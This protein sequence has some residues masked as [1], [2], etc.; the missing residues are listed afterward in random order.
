MNLA[1]LYNKFAHHI[2]SEIEYSTTRSQLQIA[3]TNEPIEYYQAISEENRIAL[4]HREVGNALGVLDAGLISPQD[5]KDGLLRRAC[6]LYEDMLWKRSAEVNLLLGD[7]YY[8]GSGGYEN[9][10]KAYE[11]YLQAAELGCA[12]AIWNVGFMNENGQGVPQDFMI[13]AIWYEKLRDI[14]F[15][16]YV[17]GSLSLVQLWFHNPH[18]SLLKTVASFMTFPKKLF[19]SLYALCFTANLLMIVLLARLAR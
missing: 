4:S 11:M 15:V 3:S 2:S 13:A 12:E 1:Y 17:T 19:I 16:G 7:C 10:T 8:H 9:K 18:S 14:D 6:K 5:I